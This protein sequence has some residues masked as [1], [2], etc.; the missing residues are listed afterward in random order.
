MEKTFLKGI[1]DRYRAYA[2]DQNRQYRRSGVG[3]RCLTL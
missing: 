3:M 1:V 2:S